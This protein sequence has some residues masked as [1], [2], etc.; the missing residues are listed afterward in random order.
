MAEVQ[1]EIAF[2]VREVARDKAGYAAAKL[3]ARD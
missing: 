2:N 3:D 1:R